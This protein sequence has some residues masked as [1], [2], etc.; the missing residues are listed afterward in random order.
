MEKIHI[1]FFFQQLQRD[2]TFALLTGILIERFV[3]PFEKLERK[4]KESIF[5][6]QPARIFVINY[7]PR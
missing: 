6:I 4:K 5:Q 2:S 1:F 3:T 7:S